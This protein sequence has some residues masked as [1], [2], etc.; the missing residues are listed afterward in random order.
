MDRAPLPRRRL[1][2]LATGTALAVVVWVLLVVA[3]VRLVGA[4]SDRGVGGWLLVVL[5]SAGAAA[6][7]FV[8]LLLG[9]R[10]VAVVRRREPAPAP[11]RPKGGKRAAR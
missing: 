3:A 4:A 6:A 1:L 11:P 7:L 10:L 8:G 5:V 9:V 2:T